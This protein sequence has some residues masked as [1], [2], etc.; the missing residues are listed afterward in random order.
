MLEDNPDDV[1]LTRLILNKNEISFNI[2]V[3]DNVND[4]TEY[5]IKGDYDLI[6]SDFRLPGFNGHDALK[7]YQEIKCKKPFIFVSGTLGE[8]TAVKLLKSGATDYVLKDNL[9]KLPLAINRAMNEYYERTEKIRAEVEKNKLILNLKKHNEELQNFINIISH[10]LRGPVASLRGLISIFNRADYGDEINLKIMEEM[11]KKCTVLNDTLDDLKES[12][13]NVEAEKFEDSP[14]DLLEVI[15]KIKTLISDQFANKNVDIKTDFSLCHIIHSKKNYIFSI[16]YNLITNGIKH[17][18]PGRNPHIQIKC[19]ENSDSYLISVSD[20]GI[21]MDF[22]KIDKG[23]IFGLYQ[24]YN[25]NADG[26]GLGLFIV[27]SQI[28]ALNGKIDVV[29]KPEKGST[30][31]VSLKK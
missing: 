21:G 1:E 30:F 17:G 18:Y 26:K 20:N 22:K 19:R 25:Q 16:L 31:L 2:H 15:N 11:E 10:N 13:Y 29:S 5:L 12:L 28:D 6:L 8:E 4:Y 14:V 23:K 7:L 24:R 3:V 9:K 27:K